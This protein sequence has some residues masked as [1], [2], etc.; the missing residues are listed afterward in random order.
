MAALL[1]RFRWV[2]LLA[3]LVVAGLVFAFW[4]A[5]IP[6]DVGKVTRGPMRVGITDDGVTRVEEHF[7][8]SAPVTGYMQRIEL[9]PGDPIRRGDLLTR[10]SGRPSTPLDPRTRQQLQAELAAARAGQSSAATTL[11]QARRDLA[12]AEELAKRG[13]LPRAQLENARS[14]VS[15][16]VATLAEANAGLARVKAALAQSGGS[17]GQ[18]GFAVAVRSPANGAILSVLSESEGVIPEGTPL[19]TVGDPRQ[20]EAVIDF[21]SRDAVQIKPGN[22]VEI[23]Q[24][25]GDKPIN[26]FVRRV[27]PFGKLKVSALGVEEQRVNVIVG[28]APEAAGQIARLG[29]G[30]QVDGTVIL[31]ETP[32]V[33]RVPIGAL[34]RGGDGNWHVFVVERV[35][36]RERPVRIGHINDEYGEVLADVNG[37]KGLGEGNQVVLNPGNALKDGSRVTIR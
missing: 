27:E 20:I 2:L 26:G 37:E 25:G 33:V 6:V 17:T 11:A 3:G 5:A 21:L 28:F 30:Y 18:A 14:R 32:Q 12:R 13:F 19:A 10:M 1:R 35:K 23:T 31:W 4:P 22:R 15:V 9:E 24:W 36:A 16:A 8:I 34:F 7:V 29:H